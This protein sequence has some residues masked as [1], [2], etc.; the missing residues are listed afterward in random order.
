MNWK[1]IILSVVLGSI[2]WYAF[3]LLVG[4]PLNA[5][6]FSLPL[7]ASSFNTIALVIS[8]A[9]YTPFII[10]FMLLAITLWK[11]VENDIL[12]MGESKQR[13][14]LWLGL[15]LSLLGIAVGGVVWRLV[16]SNLSLLL[17]CVISTILS[18]VVSWLTTS[19]LLNI[20]L[21]ISTSK[22][23]I[24]IAISSIFFLF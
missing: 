18:F 1:N 20:F 15:Y 8:L 4:I 12:D 3:F 11:F 22:K 7:L 9:I 6:L 24:I 21:D 10:G 17:N 2:L 14:I 23:R 16:P 5:I 13:K 19:K